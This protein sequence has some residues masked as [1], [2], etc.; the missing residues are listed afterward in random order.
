[1]IAYETGACNILN[2]FGEMFEIFIF[3]V[4]SHWPAGTGPSLCGVFR[5]TENKC[6]YFFQDSLGYTE[7]HFQTCVDISL[8]LILLTLEFNL[9]FVIHSTLLRFA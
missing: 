8:L 3:L 7:R 1:M 9:S 4:K 5:E 2:I 6:Q